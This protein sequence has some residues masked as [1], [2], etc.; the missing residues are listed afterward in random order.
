ML[1]LKRLRVLAEVARQ[2]S[3]SGAA[4]ELYLSQSAVS[5]Q[6]ATLKKE[7]GMSLLSDPPGPKL[8]DAGRASS[9]TQ[10]AAVA[11]LEEAGAQLEG[12]RRLEGG[13]LRLSVLSD[14]STPSAS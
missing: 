5:Q 12:N 6:V 14:S 13:R 8:N 2:G 4:E 11:R 9:P 7:V 3:F 10:E 1:D